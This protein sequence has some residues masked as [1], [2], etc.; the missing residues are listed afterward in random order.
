MSAWNQFE[1]VQKNNNKKKYI[2]L[3]NLKAHFFPKPFVG[4]IW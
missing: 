4:H 1:K 2:N 3:K